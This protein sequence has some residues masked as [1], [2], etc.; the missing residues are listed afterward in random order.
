M[1]TLDRNGLI[2]KII[3]IVKFELHV[4]AKREISSARI[5][6]MYMTN[7]LWFSKNES[8]QMRKCRSSVQYR[9]ETTTT[10]EISP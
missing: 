3:Q 5:I 4:D 9:I 8:H 1:G 6:T 7:F 10:L 2:S